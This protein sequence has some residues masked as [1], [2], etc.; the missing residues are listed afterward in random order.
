ME[1]VLERAVAAGVGPVVLVTSRLGRDDALASLAMGMSIPVWAGSEWDVLERMTDAARAWDADTVVRLTGDCPFLDPSVVRMVHDSYELAAGA[2]DYMSNDTS[3]SGYP[4]GL[5]AEVFSKQA[6]E[7]AHTNAGMRQD[8]E[9]VTQ[10]IRRHLRTGVVNCATG[11][12]SSR[13]LSVDRPDDFTYAQ[14]IH[15]YLARGAFDMADTL[16]ACEK[17]DTERR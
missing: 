17:L 8:R 14:A 10:W 1:H 5:D 11:D 3:V 6:L 2:V 7:Q 12:F 4:D 16:A 13:K 9:H 15:R